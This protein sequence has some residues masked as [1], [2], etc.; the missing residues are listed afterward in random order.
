MSYR[1]AG[2][3]ALATLALIVMVLAL[4]LLWH[5]VSVDHAGTA[6]AA[7]LAIVAIVAS[8]LPPVR[9]PVPLA[10]AP[11]GGAVLEVD[12]TPPDSDRPPELGELLRC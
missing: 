3:V 5:V 2:G 8:L 7:C 6:V 10:A 11:A 1:F 9:R 12:R 4:A